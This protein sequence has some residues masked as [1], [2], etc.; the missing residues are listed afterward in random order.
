MTIIIHN[1]WLCV[2]NM[3]NADTMLAQRPVSL[4]DI[5]LRHFIQLKE[6][7]KMHVGKFR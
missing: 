7:D 6:I 2:L 1:I 4:I 5:Y 3:L